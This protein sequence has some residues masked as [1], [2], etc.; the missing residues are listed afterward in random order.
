MK[1][2]IAVALPILL[3]FLSVCLA[4]T[5]PTIE[6]QRSLGGSSYDRAYSIYQT[7]DGGF[8]VAGESKSNDGDVSGNHGDKDYWVVKLNSAGDIV[9]QRA[10]GGNSDDIASSIRQTTDGGFIVAGR[11]SS[12]D[13]DVSGN[14]GLYDYW[15]VKL[16]PKKK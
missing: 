10:L 8:I 2:T 3:L 4:Q 6:W 16:S 15:V 7:T 14:H 5:P 9:W 11:S 1:P 13:G 12:N